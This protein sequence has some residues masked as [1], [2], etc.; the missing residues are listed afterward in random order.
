VANPYVFVVGCP[1]SGTTLLQRMLDSHPL[2]TVANDPHF[3]EYG[4]RGEDGDVP[5]TAKL[6]ERVLSYRTFGR[7]GLSVEEARAAARRATTYAEFVRTLFTALATKRN[8]PLAGEKTPHYVRFL[9]LLHGLFPQARFIHIIRDGRDVALSTLEWARPDRGPGRFRLWAS[10]PVAVCALSWRWHVAT[11]RRD[12]SPLGQLY[13][14]V[15]YEALLEDPE[16]ILRELMDVIELPFAR[17]MLDYHRGK[18][19]RDPGLTPKDAWLPPTLGLRDWR[20]Q[21]AL[22]D[23]EL[24][25]ALAGD[26]LSSLGYERAFSTITPEVDALASRCRPAWERELRTR[27]RRAASRLDPFPAL[28]AR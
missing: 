15:R 18:T 28:E 10:E 2:L 21:M 24:F 11:G 23:V 8:K 25:E 12:G 3:I 17:E 16:T 22:E 14:E 4:I 27:R 19:R 1:R 6:V 5:L 26:L 9:P 13:R 20:A 7:L